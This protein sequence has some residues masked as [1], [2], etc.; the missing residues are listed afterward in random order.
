MKDYTEESLFALRLS[1]AKKLGLDKTILE[2]ESNAE[3]TAVGS[4]HEISRKL[5][6]SHLNSADKQDKGK[7]EPY[8]STHA[9]KESVML[10]ELDWAG[11][12][13]YPYC[14]KTSDRYDYFHYMIKK[15]AFKVFEGKMVK[16]EL[17]LLVPKTE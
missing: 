13:E 16:G 7:T 8:K 11:W 2:F 15:D 1:Y 10:Y 12:I 14:P 5:I 3:R 4:T 9:N 6:R 17:G